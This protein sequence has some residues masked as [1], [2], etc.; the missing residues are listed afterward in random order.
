MARRG[1]AGRVRHNTHR[2]RD[3]VWEPGADLMGTLERIS[4]LP[5]PVLD[6]DLARLAPLREAPG[7]PGRLERRRSL[8][9]RERLREEAL[10]MLSAFIEQLE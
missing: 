2:E 1:G 8:S 4:L 9:E 6:G 10:G 3:Q 5:M 7:E